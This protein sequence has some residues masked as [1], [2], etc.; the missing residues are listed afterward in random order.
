MAYRR[1]AEIVGFTPSFFPFVVLF[2]LIMLPVRLVNWLLY[3]T[4]VEGKTNLRKFSSAI[5]VSNHTMLMDPAII[6]YAL[7]R[8]RTY[9]TMLEETALIPFLGTFVRLL[10]AL[11][12]PEGSGSLL[13]FEGAAQR[14]LFEL[15]FLHFFPEGECYQW[16]QEIQAFQPGAFLLACRLGIPV[17]P[18]TTV[19]KRRW[20]GRT[21][22]RILGRTVALPPVVTV[23]IGSPLQ[24]LVTCPDSRTNTH[25]LRRA[26]F[27]MAFLVRESMQNT[28]N[29]RGG[30]KEICRGKMPRL[31]KHVG[32]PAAQT[33]VRCAR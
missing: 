6:A 24:P 7:G 15:G 21:S 33:P 16:N 3:R 14:A 18:I 30:S 2:Q 25:A 26:A 20:R 27:C 28:I 17:I 19:L 12:I 10:G 29:S 13:F 5:L 8:R 9:F 22:V 31:V 1:G 23:V 32:A 4:R 11:P